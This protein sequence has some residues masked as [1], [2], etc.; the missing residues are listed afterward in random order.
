MS[1]DRSASQTRGTDPDEPGSVAQMIR[2][3]SDTTRKV[4]T[5]VLICAVWK[6]GEKGGAPGDRV[7]VDEQYTEV[8]TD[9]RS[10]NR[11]AAE[12]G[13]SRTDV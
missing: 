5:R 10:I 11:E 2:S 13:S 1:R 3:L 8:G 4:P 12:L 9:L 6:G 7:P